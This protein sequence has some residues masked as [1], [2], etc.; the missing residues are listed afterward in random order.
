MKKFIISA[1]FF[2]GLFV[3]YGGLSNAAMNGP[4]EPGP[5]AGWYSSEKSTEPPLQERVSKIIGARVQ[6]PKGEYLG[7]VTDL[8]VNPEDGRIAFAVLSHGGVLGIPM[9]FAAVPFNALKFNSNKSIY[10]LDMSKERMASAPSFDRNH[11]PD[12]ADKSWGAEI[13]RFYGVAPYWED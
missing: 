4:S 2:L 13:Y 10:L 5:M 8:M 11:W 1:M 6:N 3:L 12:V 7:S 9:R